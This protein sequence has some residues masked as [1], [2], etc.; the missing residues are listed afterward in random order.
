MQLGF[1]EG[2]V[3]LGP[4]LPVCCDVF[5]PLLCGKVAELPEPAVP[6]LE[7]CGCF[8]GAESLSTM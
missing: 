1:A 2:H 8:L 4:Y 6:I 3:H 7:K 5:G